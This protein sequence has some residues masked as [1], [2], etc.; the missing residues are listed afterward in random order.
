M[1]TNYFNITGISEGVNGPAVPLR[2][3]IRALQST[4]PDMFNLYI[5]GLQRMQSLPKA[6]RLSWFQIAGI[7]GRP[8]AAWDNVRGNGNASGY[9]THSSILFLTWHRPY[10]ALFEQ[11]LF[12][13]VKAAV[14]A[15]PAGPIKD[16]FTRLAPSFRMP[17]WDWAADARVPD[18]VL[19]QETIEV[20]TATGRQIIRNP[21]YSY[22]FGSINRAE[23][24]ENRYN[25]WLNTVR[26]PNL[27]NINPTDKGNPAQV[28]AQ[29]RQIE[30]LPNPGTNGL[31]LRDR[32]YALLSRNNYQNFAFFSNDGWNNNGNPDDYDSLESV[33]NTIHGTIGGGGH[34]ST[35]AYAG[36][37]PI[38]WLHHT[39]VDRIFA[40]WQV[41]NPN[42]YVVDQRARYSTFWSQ[43]NG[44]EGPTTTLLPFHQ[45]NSTYWTS[46]TCRNLK[47][48]GSTYPELI[49]WGVVGPDQVRVN[50]QRAVQTLYG[51]TAPVNRILGEAPGAIGASTFTGGPGAAVT[52][53][54]P[55]IPQTD[56]PGDEKTE[57]YVPAQSSYGQGE[58][59]PI[60]AENTGY[61]DLIKDGT[62]Y[63]Y[64]CNVRADKYAAG[65]SFNVHI[66]LGEFNS[67]ATQRA[68]DD[69]LVG[70]F[71]IFANDPE[72]TG[73][74]KCQNEA[75]DGLIV[76]GSIPLTGALLD[77]I[78]ELNSLEPENVIP[79]LQSKLHWR[80]NRPDDTPIPREEIPSLKVG[81][82]SVPVEVPS[83]DHLLPKYGEWQ[84]HYQVTA[85]RT[86]GL[87]EGDD[88]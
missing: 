32:V 38:F 69:N 31:N 19:N 45:N 26:Y 67:D 18:V 11:S 39:N 48:F 44:T 74:E 12:E 29:M 58:Q 81:V 54:G 2:Q 20:E 57:G 41:L 82:A 22:N 21:L 84:P 64:F 15:F 71:S 61:L 37:D 8:Y 55:G 78:P 75:E 77:R 85:G 3:E 59:Q 16:K 23:F 87:V 60:Q 17:Y 70:T 88:L 80:C 46:L 35:P 30:K 14:A 33:H 66:F 40:I 72:T 62:V 86:A 68:Y 10:L 79:Y 4:N 27:R 1:A 5:L 65:G 13:N 49:D 83:P 24:P 6:D 34:M 9:C 76:T 36:F 56:G 52:V 50:V 43:A 73:C 51:R 25:T 63:E 7:H 53:G 42:S 28:A 47:T